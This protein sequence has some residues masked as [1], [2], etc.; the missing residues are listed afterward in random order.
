MQPCFFA[1]GVWLA[2]L[3][4]AFTVFSFI[5]LL[6]FVFLHSFNDFPSFLALIAGPQHGRRSWSR[7]RRKEE[8]EEGRKKGRETHIVKIE[9]DTTVVDENEISHCINSLDLE[10]V[11]VVGLQEP[12]VF[13][14]NEV[15]RCLFCP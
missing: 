9:I 14:L 10:G 2:Q 8:A 4:W 3:S 1:G 7:G 6:S 5:L 12:G 11:A 13:L 15:A